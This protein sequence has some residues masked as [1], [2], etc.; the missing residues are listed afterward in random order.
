MKS[1]LRLA[2]FL[3]AVLTV[4]IG[5][6]LFGIETRINRCGG[7][8]FSCNNGKC[9]PKQ[10]ICDSEDDCG[11]NSD[12]TSCRRR[13]CSSLE[14][15]CKGGNCIPQ[16]F[17]CD[18]DNDCPESDDEQ[19]SKCKVCG[20]Q[21][22]ECG[23]G[24]C[25]PLTW[26]CDR[27]MDCR[28]G[29]DEELCSHCGGNAHKCDN[30]VCVFHTKVCDGRNDCGDGS[31]E[32]NCREDCNGSF[33]LCDNG[34]CILRSWICDGDDDCYDRS[35]EKNCTKKGTSTITCKDDEFQ[36]QDVDMCI[37]RSWVCNGNP[38]CLDATDE[39]NC[40]DIKCQQDE[41][42]CKDRKCI[43]GYMQCN[44][45][46]DCTDGSDEED[47]EFSQK[48]TCDELSCD[49]GMCIPYSSVCDGNA[50][51][52]HGEDEPEETCNVNE[53]EIDNGGC[54]Q[55]CIDTPTS[56]YCKCEMGYLLIDNYTCDDLDECKNEKTCSQICINE[57]GTV[58]CEC[59]NGYSRN[60]RD[61]RRCK[62]TEVE[63]SLI[64]TRRHDIRMM[65]LT[66]NQMR[67]IQNF[68][69]SSIALDYVFKTGEFFWSDGKDKKI[70]RSIISNVINDAI[71]V[72]ESNITVADGLAVDW[73]YNHIYWTDVDLSS[74]N[75]ANFDGSMQKT[76]ITDNLHKPR[77]IVVNPGEGWMFYSDWGSTPLI[78]K[79]GLDGTLRTV[80]VSQDVHWPNGLAL[81]L[82]KRRLYWI[83]A[84]IETI[85]SCNYDGGARRT[86]MKP[87]ELIAHP[88]SIAVFE[89]TLYWT[90][91]IT[92]TICKLDL[93]DGS[94]ATA[95]TEEGSLESPMTVHVYHP[96]KQ[97]HSVNHC[98]ERRPKCSHFCLPTP[99]ADLPV[100]T[101]P[102]NPTTCACPDGLLLA[103]DGTRCLTKELIT[104]MNSAP[105]ENLPEE[106]SR[107][108]TD[109][110][111]VSERDYWTKDSNKS[112]SNWFIGIF[113]AATSLVLL[114]IAVLATSYFYRR[115]LRRDV[116]SMSF[117][118]Q[119][120]RRYSEDNNAPKSILLPQTSSQH[121]FASD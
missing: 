52:P 86:E 69:K 62:A 36:C 11:D 87:S 82:L 28:D 65:N 40:D 17:V 53:C 110:I 2:V 72:V 47:C 14:F 115:H 66:N 68:T 100:Q 1:L 55:I 9:I 77:A 90:D 19:P 92:R 5:G 67:L 22:F 23:D 6:V 103:D 99:Q 70:Y 37:P 34:V 12:E 13:S 109:N 116:G 117:E 27:A 112:N 26:V 15:Q 79:A 91:W 81:D 33:F 58:K 20:D 45:L 106:W 18:G 35:D 76:L 30:G 80:I 93:L 60:P 89:E 51:C 98:L 42:L 43:P 63:P 4:S 50:D 3:L 59:Y 16:S 119:V 75:V 54:S 88:F 95:I 49:D 57:K 71:P 107:N 97:P 41:F 44:N 29:K 78:E 113:L 96:L 74:I 25:I 39:S 102:N 104:E 31:D 61:H 120:Y 73:I 56:Y 114:L 7:S 32:K 118:N 84:K 48:P 24:Q 101:R 85:F 94:N 10:W 105:T 8:L 111:T 46:T 121:L 108:M 21:D 83:D 38:E 64:F